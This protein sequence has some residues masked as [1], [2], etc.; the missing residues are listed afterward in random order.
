MGAFAGPDAVLKVRA[1]KQVGKYY[2]PPAILEA[3]DGSKVT[4]K[5]LSV[6]LPA[7]NICLRCNPTSCSS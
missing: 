1:G 7:G 6:A 3:M 4:G 2:G 5:Q